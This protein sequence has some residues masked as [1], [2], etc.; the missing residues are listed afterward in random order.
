MTTGLY[1]PSLH[2]HFKSL[3][4]KS[5]KWID[6]KLADHGYNAKTGARKKDYFVKELKTYPTPTIHGHPTSPAKGRA[7]PLHLAALPP[8]NHDPVKKN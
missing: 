8:L 2:A 6:A 3:T 5:L 7:L 4:P 1:G